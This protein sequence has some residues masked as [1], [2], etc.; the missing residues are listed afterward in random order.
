MA[1]NLSKAATR[2]EF[3]G[4]PLHREKKLL[5]STAFSKSAKPLP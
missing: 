5:Y 2:S 4:P 1:Y 3:F